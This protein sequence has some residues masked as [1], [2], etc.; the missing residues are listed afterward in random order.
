MP[1]DPYEVDKT[2]G[3]SDW[4]MSM[5]GTKDGETLE[6]KSSSVEDYMRSIP[7]VRSGCQVGETRIELAVLGS[8]GVSPLVP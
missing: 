6:W 2:F 8:P 7:S 3:A 4:I 1:D 5:E